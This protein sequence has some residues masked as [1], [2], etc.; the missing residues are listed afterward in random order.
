[1]VAVLRGEVGLVIT[2]LVLVDTWKLDFFSVPEWDTWV[3]FIKLLDASFVIFPSKP[4]G[5]A[6]AVLP[7]MGPF[8]HLG[9]EQQFPRTT[10][11]SWRSSAWRPRERTGPTEVDH[12]FR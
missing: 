9:S 7:V 2:H 5:P 8:H 10:P 1:M 4:V 6:H 11:A 12:F 3:I